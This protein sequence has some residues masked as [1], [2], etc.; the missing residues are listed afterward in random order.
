MGAQEGADYPVDKS[1]KVRISLY[2]MIPHPHNTLY[3]NNNRQGIITEDL[4][5]GKP[6]LKSGKG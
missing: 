6:P 2:K 3:Q 1:P 4:A 5:S